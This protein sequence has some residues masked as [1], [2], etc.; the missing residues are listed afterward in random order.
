MISWGCQL[1]SALEY[2]H[3][4]KYIYRLLKPEHLWLNGTRTTL[5]VCRL[6]FSHGN[7]PF[8]RSVFRNTIY[9]APEVLKNRPY[10]PKC[11]VYSWA[12]TLWECFSRKRPFYECDQNEALLSKKLEPDHSLEVIDPKIIPE[13]INELIQNCSKVNPNGRPTMRSVQNVMKKYLTHENGTVNIEH[14]LYFNPDLLEVSMID[15]GFIF[16]SI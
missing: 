8:S 3:S 13:E 12:L 15:F 5:K 14:S 9:T 2:L 4:Q 7:S 10:S 11:D 1:A 6:G 16:P